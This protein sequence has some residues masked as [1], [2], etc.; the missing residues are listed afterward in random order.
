MDASWATT[1]LLV[2][3][4]ALEQRGVVVAHTTR[5]LG[6]ASPAHLL[7]RCGE[8]ER[9][10]CSS[11][12]VVGTPRTLHTTTSTIPPT[13]PSPPPPGARND[14]AWDLTQSL[15]D[16]AAGS[17]YCSCAVTFVY[18]SAHLTRQ[19]EIIKLTRILINPQAHPSHTTAPPLKYQ[20]CRH[21]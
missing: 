19:W 21:W 14:F 1:T 10:S 3:R 17:L 12:V 15:N 13:S 4:T 20:P 9:T 16:T 18:R 2:G 6:A 8:D 11:L 7:R 5:R